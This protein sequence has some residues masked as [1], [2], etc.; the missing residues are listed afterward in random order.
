MLQELGEEQPP[1][2]IW[3]EYNVEVKGE[4]GCFLYHCFNVLYCFDFVDFSPIKSLFLCATHT[5]LR[6]LYELLI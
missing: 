5:I 1:R 4:L 3:K 6:S 2:E